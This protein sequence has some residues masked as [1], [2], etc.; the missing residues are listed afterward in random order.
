MKKLTCICCGAPINRITKRCD[1][2]GTEYDIRGDDPMIR[3]ETYTNPVKEYSASVL[4]N[5]EIAVMCGE[6]YMKYAIERLAHEMMPAVLEGMQ[7]QIG[8]V[9]SGGFNDMK[10]S[11]RIRIVIP[12]DQERGRW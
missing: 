4:V 10:V 7:I 3:I 6:D 11:G 12:K 1:Y 9:W 8:E 2:C 5:R